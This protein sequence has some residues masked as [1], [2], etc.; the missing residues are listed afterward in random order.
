[1]VVRD[2]GEEEVAVLT[3]EVD[4]DEEAIGKKKTYVTMALIPCKIR[5]TKYF[6]AFPFTRFRH[7]HIYESLL[8]IQIVSIVQL[9]KSGYTSSSSLR[10][11]I[12]I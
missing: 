8:Q 2:V 11:K 10:Y 6:Q 1:M 3:T 7:F 5:Y 9:Y 4:E 12:Q